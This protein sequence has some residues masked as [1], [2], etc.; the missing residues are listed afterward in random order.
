MT[1]VGRELRTSIKTG[2][3][4]YAGVRKGF[5]KRLPPKG[6]CSK[7]HGIPEALR[8]REFNPFR[9]ALKEAPAR[10]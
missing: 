1:V 5:G 2:L 8:H 4:N 6:C 10:T 3:G 7:V 9:E